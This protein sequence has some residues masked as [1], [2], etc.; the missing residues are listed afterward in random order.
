MTTRLEARF[1]ISAAALEQC[2]RWPRAEVAIAGRSNVGKSSLLNALADERNLARTSKTPGRT[3][4]LNFFEIGASLALTDLPGYGYARMP[5][6]QAQRIAIMMREYLTR[7]RNLAAVV[8]L[9]DARRGPRDE[10]FDLAGMARARGLEV[11][12]AATKCD[13]LKRSERAAALARLEPLGGAPILCSATSG[14]G[15]D[16]LRRRIMEFSRRAV[17]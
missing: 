5:Q 13:K 9:V 16:A 8:I 6:Q 1:A 17:A 4:L 7:R 15:L 3:Q 14:E 12:V 10:E 2:P 11:I